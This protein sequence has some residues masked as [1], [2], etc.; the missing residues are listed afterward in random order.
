M[1]GS[2]GKTSVV[3]V[4]GA[5]ADGSSWNDIIASL[6]AKQRFAIDQRIDISLTSQASTAVWISRSSA[7]ASVNV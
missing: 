6:Q 4:H 5:W 7:S 3:L 2:I 1:K